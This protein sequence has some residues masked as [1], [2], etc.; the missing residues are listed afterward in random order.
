MNDKKEKKMMN[1]IAS[2]IV[3]LIF[4]ILIVMFFILRSVQ[5]YIGQN[6]VSNHEYIKTS[7][8]KTYVGENRDELTE[9][10]ERLINEQEDELEIYREKDDFIP[11]LDSYISDDLNIS[12]VTVCKQEGDNDINA[13]FLELKNKPSDDL[14]RVCGIYYSQSDLLLDSHWNYHSEEEY[15]FDGR[16]ESI[17]CVYR[18]EKICDGWYYYEEHLW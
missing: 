16:P 5:N 1:I 15:V 3:G 8:I 11:L 13:V 2:L 17:R 18:S 6:Y 9:I 14:Y 4:S 12:D 7:E 10:A